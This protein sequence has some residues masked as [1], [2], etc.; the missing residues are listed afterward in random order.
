VPI[1]R[2][3]AR[4]KIKGDRVS[5][6]VPDPPGHAGRGRRHVRRARSCRPAAGTALAAMICLALAACG[7][8]HPAAQ[9]T[10]QN[11]D[12]RAIP[13]SYNG[14]TMASPA[15][16]P[17]LTGRDYLGQ[18]V[19]LAADRGHAV[20]VTFLY[21]HCHDTCPLITA[22]L[23]AVLGQLGPKASMVRI[24]AV[25]IDPG[26][27][28]PA[29]VAAF[30]ARHEMTGKM[31]YLIGSRRT[32]EPLWRA[33]GITA[34]DPTIDDKVSHTSLVYGIT[35][36]GLVTVVYPANFNPSDVAHDVPILAT[37]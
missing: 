25:S 24:V 7:G 22:E 9:E 37:R 17:P 34:S 2:K 36:S 12:A 21:T 14:P 27:D 20:L 33:W 16:E 32:L 10:Q 15:P 29:P 5:L 13:A 30:L 1:A 3:L 6:P 8:S 4:T 28:T 19:D 26:G 31:K 11:A 35:A 18:P 23:H